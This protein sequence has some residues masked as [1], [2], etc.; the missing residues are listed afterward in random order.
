[1]QYV[2]YLLGYFANEEDKETSKFL[3]LNQETLQASVIGLEELNSL[4]Q[5]YIISGDIAEITGIEETIV[6]ENKFWGYVEAEYRNGF[7]LTEKIDKD[8]LTRISLSA[9]DKNKTENYILPVV[10]CDN[11]LLERETSTIYEYILVFDRDNNI[12][13]GAGVYDYNRETI[14]AVVDN[15]ALVLPFESYEQ[16]TRLVGLVYPSDKLMSMP[17]K[18]VSVFSDKLM[19]VDFEF[20]EKHL[21]V[22]SS[23][24]HLVFLSDSDFDSLIATE[25]PVYPSHSGNIALKFVSVPTGLKMGLNRILENCLMSLSKGSA[26]LTEEEKESTQALVDKLKQEF[27]VEV[28]ITE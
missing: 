1:M 26:V 20:K 17:C 23:I 21:S 11:S 14:H 27:G 8:I 22:P 16:D 13:V 15:K 2:Y 9:L 12:T 4:Y 5:N 18:G 25:M 6:N 19:V 28:E 7:L 10:L 3:V 24:E